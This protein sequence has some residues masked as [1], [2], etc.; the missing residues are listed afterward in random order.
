MTPSAAMSDAIDY[1]RGIDALAE[2]T[3]DFGAS[4]EYM[5]FLAAHEVP[6]AVIAKI[7]SGELDMSDAARAA[8][9]RDI[10]LN[11]DRLLYRYDKTGKPTVLGRYRN[12]LQY[13]SFT[14]EMAMSAA[15][16]AYAKHPL[17]G[18]AHVAGLD[19]AP[20]PLPVADIGRRL[21]RLQGGD[22]A[23]WA[24]W[25]LFAEKPETGLAASQKTG[26]KLPSVKFPEG[27]ITD[28]AYDWAAANQWLDIPA[29]RYGALERGRRGWGELES[30]ANY[31]V[32]DASRSFIPDL[33]EMG[34]QGVLVSD[35]APRSVAFFGPSQE[36]PMPAI[37]HGALS[38]LDPEFRYRRNMFMSIP[39]LAPLLSGTNSQE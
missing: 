38:A 17:W 31:G 30:D 21:K 16:A 36:G 13:T 5:D 37:R 23:D 39:L 27:D 7:A 24:E 22:H 35:E 14:P 15:Q 29:V 3:R 6:Q 12:G 26:T 28:P 8:R 10:G 19:P 34:Y 2:H 9:A 20:N 11:P 4:Q 1:Q 32:W 18:P 25:E 33:K